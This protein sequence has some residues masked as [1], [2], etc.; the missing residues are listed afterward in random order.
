MLEQQ[1]DQKLLQKLSPQ[2]IQLIK[3]LQVPTASIEQRVE[4]ELEE[5]PALEEGKEQEETEDEVLPEEEEAEATEEELIEDD[6]DIS[7]YINDDDVADYKVN[8]YYASGKKDNQEEGGVPPIVKTTFHDYLSDQLNMMDLGKRKKKLAQQLI[9]T[10]GED[11]YL[12][13]SLQAI[14]DDL[15]F[16]QNIQTSPE[17]LE[18]V[19]ELIQDF[20]P[21][22]VGARDLQ[23]CLLLQLER[24][25]Q[26]NSASKL[27][28]TILQDHFDAFTKKKYDQL[29]KKLSISREE[30]KAAFDEILK[31]NPKPGSGYSDKYDK[32]PNPQYIIPDF[33]ITNNNG[34]LELTLNERNAPELKVSRQYQNMLKGYKA[35]KK[36][37][38][39]HKEAILFIKQK[40]DAAKWFI[41]AIKQRQRTLR[42]TMKAIMKRQE[43]FFQTGDEADLKPMILKDIAEDVDLDI[44]TISRVANSKYVQTE[45]GT[46]PLKYFFSEGM[47]KKSGESIS[48]KAVKQKLQE[49][50][51]NENKQKP[52]SDKKL[53]DKLKEKGYK[54][55][56]RTVAKYREQMNIPVA[57]LRKEIT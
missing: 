36:K 21:A 30:L 34:E 19:L 24:K 6:F 2:Q 57:R 42:S 52:L 33:F 1:L 7:D 4:Q 48:N 51:D 12:R 54:I 39:K 15:A 31:L 8:N 18:E 41:D 9:G 45:F 55:A 32:S 56:R 5:N 35:S 40:I 10:I 3:L 26:D 44:S 38:K 46:F 11:G 17:E 23:E 16:T 37:D 53:T 50:I 27:A 22:G 28:Y 43:K 14:T 25:E 29:I 49:I 13:R 47:K 20:D